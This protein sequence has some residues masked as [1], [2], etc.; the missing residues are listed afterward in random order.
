LLRFEA[1]EGSLKGTV[2]VTYVSLKSVYS[3]QDRW[4]PSSTFQPS[5]PLPSPPL[6]PLPSY[7]FP[8][9]QSSVSCLCD[10]PGGA[11]QCS[12]LVTVV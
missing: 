6:P 7:Q 3:I 9:A 12:R 2:E 11:S 1:E 8:L 5:P 4:L 10:C